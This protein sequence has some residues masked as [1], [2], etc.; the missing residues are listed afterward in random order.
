MSDSTQ[1]IFAA[2]ADATRRQL[3]ERLSVE[4]ARTATELANAL[5]ITRQGVTKHLGILAEAGLV[6]TEKEGR[7]KRYSL[8]PEPLAESTSWVEAVTATWDRRL[9]RLHDHLIQ[10]EQVDDLNT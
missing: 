6:N 9:Q 7:E 5:P 1:L 2:L 3:I 4:G 10:E 8:T